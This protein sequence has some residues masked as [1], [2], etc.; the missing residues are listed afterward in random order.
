M[1]DPDVFVHCGID[2]NVYTGWAFGFGIDRMT[3]LRHAVP[4]LKLFF[5][6]DLRFLEQYPC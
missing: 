6:G 3:M 1:I 2:P 5:E 4:N